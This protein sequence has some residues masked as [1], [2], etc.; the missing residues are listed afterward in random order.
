[1]SDTDST[2]TSDAEEAKA[3]AADAKKTKRNGVA[4]DA[5]GAHA[6]EAAPETT[7]DDE[8]ATAANGAAERAASAAQRAGV[9]AQR[10]G[11]VL[12]DVAGDV[13]STVS[14][15]GPALIDAS[16]TGAG[17]AAREV[18]GASSENLMLGTVFSAGLAVGLVLARVPRGLSVLA[19]VPVFA[20][21]GTLLGRRVG[22]GGASTRKT[23]GSGRSKG[24]S[25]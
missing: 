2:P 1:M 19:L 3:E 24:T 25:S 15:K 12:T 5:D 7:L 8:A 4:A 6:G 9:A 22:I 14:K 10:A 13:A 21:G 18:Q 11:E 20:M 23:P 17:I 16:R